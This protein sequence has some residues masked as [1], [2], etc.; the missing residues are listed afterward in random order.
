MMKHKPLVSV[1]T[2]FLNAERFIQEAIESVF[3][4]TYNTWELL[5][6]DD[7]ST[8]RSTD[9]ALQYANNYPEKVRYLEHDGH[10]NRGMSAS[11]NLGFRN[12]KGKYVALLDA[13]D[14][15]LPHKLEQQVDILESQ[16]EAGM[17]YGATFYWYSWSG[18]PEDFTRDY[19]PELGFKPKNLFKPPRL[20]TLA[21][22]LGKAYA[23]CPSDLIFCRDVIDQIGGFEESFQ[24]IYQL[25]EDQAFLAKVYLKIPVYVSSEC[26]AKYRLHPDACVSV[27]TKAGRYHK[28]RF[29]F[30][31]WLEKYL[32][33]QGVKD[34]M[35]WKALQ[36]SLWSYRH[37]ILSRLY[38]I[39]QRLHPFMY[40]LLGHNRLHIIHGLKRK[41]AVNTSQIQVFSMNN[42]TGLQPAYEGYH[43]GAN[44]NMISGWVWD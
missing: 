5:L 16:I 11:R 43:D 25:Y 27:V 21:Y 35:I 2:I 17:V 36:H 30:L 14:V 32:S 26:W 6:I 34:A 24:G 12:S 3:A 18:K 20:L 44:C 39:L 29:Y 38:P 41:P 15:W 28:V 1:I 8:D 9:I 23:P 4:Q 22:S 7:G 42:L 37:P 13:D 40:H 33:K 10:K 19:V 31:N